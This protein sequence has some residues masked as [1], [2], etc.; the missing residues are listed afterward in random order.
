MDLYNILVYYKDLYKKIQY[1][2]FSFSKFDLRDDLNQI[3]RF[4]WQIVLLLGSVKVMSILLNAQV[5]VYEQI[6]CGPIYSSAC[7]SLKPSVAVGRCSSS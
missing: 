4:S 7:K 5:I 1:S 6:H 2:N 3:G